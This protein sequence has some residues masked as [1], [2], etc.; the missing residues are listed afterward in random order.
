MIINNFISDI[1]IDAYL[2]FEKG[3]IIMLPLLVLSLT[4]WILII[5]RLLFYKGEVLSAQK[6]YLSFKNNNTNNEEYKRYQNTIIFNIIK[7]ISS[8]EIKNKNT[9]LQILNENIL[10]V[11]PVIKRYLMTISILVSIAPLLGLLGTVYGIVSTFD[12]ISAIGT[13]N[14]QSLASGISEALI[15]TKTGLIIAI[16]GFFFSNKLN[17]KSEIIMNELYSL[18]HLLHEV[19]L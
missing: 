1:F 2:Y 6:I 3:G 14:A 11:K 12:I 15:T 13:A 10:E 19:N 18:N 17:R 4:V 5:E 8:F 16:P 9:K 7:K